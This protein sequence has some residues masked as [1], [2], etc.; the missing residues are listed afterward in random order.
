[1]YACFQRGRNP[2]CPSGYVG[3]GGARAIPIY[4]FLIQLLLI[5]LHIFLSLLGP[6]LVVVEF[7][8]HGN[9]RQYL[10]SRRP[11]FL[12][13]VGQNKEPPPKMQDLVSYSLQ[14]AKGMEFLASK[15][16][17]IVI[18]LYSLELL[19]CRF[20]LTLFHC[21]IMKLFEIRTP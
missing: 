16:V 11:T 2:G 7:A 1:M 18:V 12:D 8:P 10:R 3:G 9:L 14:I 15:M 5:R 21:I 13:S 20:Y 6:L 19:N 4:T 17:L